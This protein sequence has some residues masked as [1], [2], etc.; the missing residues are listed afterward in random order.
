MTRPPETQAVAEKAVAARPLTWSCHQ[1]FISSLKPKSILQPFSSRAETMKHNTADYAR[2]VFENAANTWW[3]RE[4]VKLQVLVN[5]PVKGCNLTDGTFTKAGAPP[6]G[7]VEEDTIKLAVVKRRHYFDYLAL[8]WCAL[9]K[10]EHT[11][12]PTCPSLNNWVNSCIFFIRNA[13]KSQIR[14]ESIETCVGVEHIFIYLSVYI[15]VI[16]LCGGNESTAESHVQ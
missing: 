9:D 14:E 12:R 8:C 2:D 10:S 16:V 13:L 3:V 1:I 7:Q 6:A 5:N 11:F 4:W 15:K